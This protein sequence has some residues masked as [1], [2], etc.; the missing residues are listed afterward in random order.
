MN[1]TPLVKDIQLDLGKRAL[2]RMFRNNNGVLQDKHGEYVRY[3]LCN[4]S[5]DLIGWKSVRITPQMV[6]QRVAVF[7][8]VEVKKPNDR[9]SKPTDDQTNFINA[10]L[11]HGGIA[12]VARSVEEARQVL[13]LDEDKANLP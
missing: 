2:V 4:G 1:E 9:K 8:A 11:L 3:G 10:V 7:C 6:G 5:S 13:N 12:G